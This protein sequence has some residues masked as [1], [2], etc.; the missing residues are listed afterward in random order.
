MFAYVYIEHFNFYVCETIGFVDWLNRGLRYVCEKRL[1]MCI[2]YD[3]S[4]TVLRWPCVV[5]RTLK[6]NYYYYPDTYTTS[7]ISI[8]SERFPADPHGN[9]IKW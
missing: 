5:D 6:S 9:I 3:L 7:M 4:L 1:E 8:L 2:A